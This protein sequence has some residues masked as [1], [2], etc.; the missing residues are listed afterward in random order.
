MLL[1]ITLSW[2]SQLGSFQLMV[3]QMNWTVSNE[4]I[5][6]LAMILVTLLTYI[7]YI[8]NYNIIIMFWY[9]LLVP[10]ANLWKQ[11]HLER[12][13]LVL[14]EEYHFYKMQ[15]LLTDLCLL[16]LNLKMSI[17]ISNWCFIYILY[18]CW[19][20]LK[21]CYYQSHYHENLNSGLFN[22]WC[23]KELGRFLN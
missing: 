10:F 2:K 23:C 22:L 12:N 6:I 14:L 3:L 11:T 18:I 13:V 21:W 7:N 15:T 9:Y 16:L 4:L 5:K 19:K 1:P 20:I 17:T 8:A